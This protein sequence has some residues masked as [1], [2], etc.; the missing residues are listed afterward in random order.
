MTT[1]QRLPLAR[2]GRAQWRVVALAA[3]LAVALGAVL[4][5]WSHPRAFEEQAGMG[6]VPAEPGRALFEGMVHPYASDLTLLDVRPRIVSDDASAEVTVHVCRVVE[7]GSAVGN[8]YDDVDE[9]CASLREPTGA[10]EATDQ[11]LVEVVAQEEGE[12]VIDG[13]DVTYRS[14]LQRGTQHTGLHLTVEVGPP[15]ST[16]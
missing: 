4:W 7:P 1:T 5:W 3:L 16:P 15:G 8:A 10:L 12:V 6:I 14:G 11:L 9:F 13:L 2:R